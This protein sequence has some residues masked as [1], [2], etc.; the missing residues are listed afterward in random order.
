VVANSVIA[1]CGCC[2]GNVAGAAFVALSGGFFP[3]LAGLR[4]TLVYSNASGEGVPLYLTNRKTWDALVDLMPET[5]GSRC[6]DLGSGLGGTTLY[7]ANKRPD[8]IFEAVETAPVPFALSWLRFKLFAPGNC[9]VRF[10]DIWQTDLSVYDRVYCFLSPQPMPRLYDKALKE[11]KADSWLISN[12][13][14]VPGHD[15]PSVM[16]VDDGRKTRLLIWQM[17]AKNQ[18]LS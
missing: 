15:A 17:T 5:S 18:T 7:L 13:F 11:M 12:S 8:L 3:D 9:S 6:I 4:F 2:C 14:D 1:A 16:E 10:A